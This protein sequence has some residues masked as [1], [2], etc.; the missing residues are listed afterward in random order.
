M[1]EGVCERCGGEVIRKEKSQWMLAITK[2][3][4]RLI[5]DLEGLRLVGGYLVPVLN[6]VLPLLQI[7]VL[8]GNDHV[9]RGAN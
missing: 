4:D 5:D 3:A 1:V 2:Y 8:R 7:G 6:L 9:G